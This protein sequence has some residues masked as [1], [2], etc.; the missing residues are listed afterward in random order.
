MKSFEE[1]ALSGFSEFH[2]AIERLP[3][4]GYNPEWEEKKLPDL[5]TCKLFVKP[6]WFVDK[7]DCRVL[8][9]PVRGLGNVIISEMYPNQ[10]K[11]YA[12][13]VDC[14][15]GVPIIGGRWG[16]TIDDVRRKWSQTKAVTN[17]RLDTQ[18][19]LDLITTAENQVGLTL[20]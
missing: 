20:E 17:T 1:I 16:I 14:A 11:T 3:Q 2:K 8:V 18:Y 7:R 12:L 6:V 10:S 19:L 5:V 9:I 4:I 15:E 13:H